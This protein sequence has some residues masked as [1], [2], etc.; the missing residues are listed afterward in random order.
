[1]KLKINITPFDILL[2]ENV[3]D[4]HFKTLSL[5]KLASKISEQIYDG[6][7]KK[8]IYD[9][10]KKNHFVTDSYIHSKDIYHEIKLRAIIYK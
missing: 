10:L 2:T 5:T 7:H 4:E 8:V 1:M 3:I 6:K 9:T